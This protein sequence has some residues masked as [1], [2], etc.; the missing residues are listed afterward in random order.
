M[1]SSQFDGPSAVLVGPETE[2]GVGQVTCT[3]LKRML[4]ACRVLLCLCVKAVFSI[5]TEHTMKCLAFLL[6]LA[7]GWWC[8]TSK[9]HGC[10][11]QSRQLVRET[12]AVNPFLPFTEIK[13]NVGNNAEPIVV[14]WDK[15]GDW[16]VIL[17]TMDELL[18]FEFKAE[19]HF[20]QMEPSPF[21]G[22]PGGSCRPAV[23]DWDGDGRLD[24]IVGA[25]AH[26]KTET[27]NHSVY[28]TQSL[29]LRSGLLTICL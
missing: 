23:A 9:R 7:Y 16:D 27:I 24:L 20:V 8:E 17:K 19:N 13:S 18:F 25:E 22:I 12:T 28:L 5:K 11:G 10:R 29:S 1:A 4:Q 2:S 26:L 21:K 3:D 6:P 15:D 14:D